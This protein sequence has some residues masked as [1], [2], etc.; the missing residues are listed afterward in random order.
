MGSERFL[1]TGGQGFIGAWI[2]KTLL[3]MNH[4]VIAYDV[5]D[6]ST[7]MSV[8]IHPDSLKKV[9]FV[10]GD[11]NNL[12]LLKEL[13]SK[14]SI[15]YVIHVAALMTPDC[16][17]DPIKGALV[18]VLGTL[19]VFEAVKTYKSRVRCIAYAS[20][21]SVLGPDEKYKSQPISDEAPALPATIYGVYKRTNEECARIYWEEEGIRSVGLRPGMVYGPGR[22]RG[23]ADPTHGVKAAL[24][25][26][27]YKIGFG[28]MANMQ[29]VADVAK[30]FI[31]CVLK[32]PQDAPAFNISGEVL[33]VQ[34]MIGYIEELIPSSKGK[35][36]CLNNRLAM[37][38]NVEDSGL[39]KLIGPFKA[40]KFREGIGI[41]VDFFRKLLRQD[42]LY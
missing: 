17:A 22:E 30:S 35:I 41:T 8:L 34:D 25:G 5:Y 6:Q 19:S 37:A 33:D 26:K 1:V 39:Q 16:K 38:I 28:G 13:I 4:D 24:L 32:A 3:E 31:S 10:H 23:F 12:D 20:S 9:E 18:N 11:I 14:K 15:T 40:T 42:K 27:E 36:T 29:F 7:R 21:G 2:V